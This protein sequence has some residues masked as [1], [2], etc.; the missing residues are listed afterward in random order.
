MGEIWPKK[1]E[2]GR[3]RRDH[4]GDAAVVRHEV[5]GG[6]DLDGDQA[7]EQHDD[8]GDEVARGAV[9]DAGQEAEQHRGQRDDDAPQRLPVDPWLAPFP[10]TF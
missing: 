10:H 1:C 5:E 4:L 9:L 8:G 3:D 2:Q 6:Q 7:G